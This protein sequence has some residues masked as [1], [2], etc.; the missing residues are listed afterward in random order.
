MGT[1]TL[2]IQPPVSSYSPHPHEQDP[3]LV[4][5]DSLTT[6]KHLKQVVLQ[7]LVHSLTLAL[8]F[9]LPPATDFGLVFD[10]HI[11]NDTDTLDTVFEKVL[12]TTTRTCI[13][14]KPDHPIEDPLP[15]LPAYTLFSPLPQPSNARWTAQLPCPISTSSFHHRDRKAFQ[16]STS[17]ARL[18]PCTSTA[19]LLPQLQSQP[20]A[21]TDRPRLHGSKQLPLL[22]PLQKR[23]AHPRQVPLSGVTATWQK[24]VQCQV[25]LRKRRHILCHRRIPPYILKSWH[26]SSTNTFS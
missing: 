14:I 17:L 13:H 10:G 19:S 6:V 7:H 23:A 22:Q 4:T 12:Y 25:S 1:L 26:H 15:H 24:A 16:K 11:L 20:T 2:K 18:L 3:F 8:P 5:V 9:P 21:H